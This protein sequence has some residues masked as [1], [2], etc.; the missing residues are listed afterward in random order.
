MTTNVYR[1]VFDQEVSLTE[2]EQT[3]LLA[4]FATEG[5]LGQAQVRLDFGY[6][7]D[8]SRCTIIVDGSTEVGYAIVQIFTGLV[9][10]EFGEQAFTVR[11]VDACPAAI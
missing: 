1:F 8:E 10:R 7:I 4:S 11:R 6:F 9:L 2:A 3:L 5:L